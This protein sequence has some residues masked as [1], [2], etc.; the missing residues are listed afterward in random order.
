MIGMDRYEAEL[1]QGLI[2][3]QKLKTRQRNHADYNDLWEKNQSHSTSTNLCPS[4]CINHSSEYRGAHLKRWKDSEG[5]ISSLGEAKKAFRSC[6]NDKKHYSRQAM[7]GMSRIQF[8]S[9]IW[10]DT[11]IQRK[12]LNVCVSIYASLCTYRCLQQD[13]GARVD[14][15]AFHRRACITATLLHVCP[16]WLDTVTACQSSARPTFLFAC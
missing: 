13:E 6:W 10:E 9:L 2:C 3:M 4:D 14:E 16:H 12:K 1:K 8:Y 5:Q 11:L 15:G 7:W